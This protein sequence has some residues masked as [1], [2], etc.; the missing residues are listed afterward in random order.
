MIG[1]AAMLIALLA[2]PPD[3]LGE[4]VTLD[5]VMAYAEAHAPRLKAAAARIEGAR[6]TA[7]TQDPW[8]DPRL[9]LSGDPLPIE[10]RNGP[11]WGRATLTQPLPWTD[12]LAARRQAAEAG[13]RAAE[14]ERDVALI[15]VRFAAEQAFV[16]LRTSREEAR[17]IGELLGL[18]RALLRSAEDRVAVDRGHHAD[19]IE[20]RIEVA[21][22][23]TVAVDLAQAAA[24]RQAELNAVI[25]RPLLDEVGPLAPPDETPTAALDR[26]LAAAADHPALKRNAARL[27]GA[28]ARLR[29]AET[30]GRPMFSVG[31]GYTLV[32]E[33]DGAMAPD[34]GR[35]GLSV[36]VGVA[37]PLWRGEADDGA[38]QAAAAAVRIEEA[39]AAAIAD[40]IE[41][42]VVEQAV[43]AETALRR[44]KLY[45]D[46]ALPLAEERLEV[47]T[48]AYAAGEV[49]FE[50]V[51]DAERAK[52]R[53]A[54]AAVRAAEEFALARSALARAVGRSVEGT[55]DE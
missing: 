52:E 7:R 13:V 5:A 3:A 29:A 33:P 39:E 16:R 48:T 37:L 25:G 30:N 6:A 27:D 1:A 14:T 50:R 46:T 8:P 34:P 55:R 40:V 17:I 26:L 20:A 45:R 47:L 35:D 31:L 15:E 24:T 41:W 53:Y 38:R 2:S 28:R 32:G 12:T 4:A 42:R 22:L 21:R 10:T 43:R 23:E 51:L 19:V 36:Q 49:R 44:L 11:I 54:V 9:M 18:G